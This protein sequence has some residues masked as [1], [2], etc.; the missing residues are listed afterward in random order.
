[1]IRLARS[2]FGGESAVVAPALLNKVLVASGCAGRIIEV[3]AYDAD[4]PASHSYRGETPRN[5]VMFG[6]PG[7]LYVYVIY[8]IHHCANVVTGGLG[9]GAAVLLRAVSPLAG[10]EAMR[11]RR[12]GRRAL[13][14]GPAKL[15]QAF[16]LDLGANGLDLCTRDGI[17]IFDDGVAPPRSPRVGP[18]IGL[19]K[20]V[21]TPWRWRVPAVPDA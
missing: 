9:D 2:F 8:G 18:R 15:C 14:D 16:D 20:G 12:N 11:V 3:E 6:P 5:R 4:D 21:A 7:H 13:A 19:T 1:M 17:G 10:I